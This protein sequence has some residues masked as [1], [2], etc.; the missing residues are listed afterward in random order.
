MSE[1]APQPQKTSPNAA[2][3]RR[4]LL[5][6]AALLW[7][8]TW[9]RLGPAIYLI[10]T[11]AALGLFDIPYWISPWLH[12]AVLAGFALALMTSGKRAT[13]LAAIPRR[14]PR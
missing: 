6:R 10:G 1:Q 13:V 9:P 8:Q 14:S 2:L 4:V 12:A 7:E 11:V 3:E 5:A